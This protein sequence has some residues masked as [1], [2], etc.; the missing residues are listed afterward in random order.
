MNLQLVL[1]KEAQAVDNAGAIIVEQKNVDKLKAG[2]YLFLLDGTTV[3]KDGATDEVF[4]RV[5]LMVGLANA[6][7]G[8][9]L[10]T[11]VPIPKAQVLS[12]N[13]E[14]YAPGVNKVV[15]I[16]FASIA[17]D[18]VGEIAMSLYDLSYNRTIKNDRINANIN[19]KAT[20]TIAQVVTRLATK[21]NAHGS[22]FPVANTFV[23]ATV[24]TT[25]LRL[26]MSNPN[27]DFSM[28]LDG[29][30]AGIVPVTITEAVVSLTDSADILRTEKEYS[31]NLGNGGYDVAGD[32]WYSVPVQTNLATNYDVIHVKWQGEHDTPQNRQ[33]SAV[34]WLKIAVPT[35][36]G[37]GFF[38]ELRTVL[39]VPFDVTP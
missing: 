2:S 38:D 14:V 39:G 11:S 32:A 24:S 17:A 9:T 35:A 20:E 7:K 19:K 6:T 18:A 3:H 29:L 33:R 30:A 15:E 16:D 13:R 28:T 5:Q 26:T 8:A 10:M 12:V 37:E 22:T 25:K 36:Q 23:T 1:G 31:G 4:E 34:L 21:I 27:I